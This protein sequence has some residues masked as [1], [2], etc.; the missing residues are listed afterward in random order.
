MKIKYQ[1]ADETLEIEV[2]EE[3]GSVLIEL[4]RRERNSNR[5][6]T[7]RHQSYS[8]DNEKMDTLEDW[9]TDIEANY[10]C[11]ADT[12]RLTVALEKLLP[13]QRELVRK[14]FFQETSITQIAHEMGVSQQAISKQLNVIYKNLKNFLNLGL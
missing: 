7:R 10:L 9:S 5:Q 4:D 2:S 1:F 12:E 11:K 8:G 14:V 6:E 3:W 13:Q